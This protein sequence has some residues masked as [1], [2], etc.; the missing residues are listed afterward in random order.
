[1]DDRVFDQD[2]EYVDE[3]PLGPPKRREIRIDVDDRLLRG[4]RVSQGLQGE[5]DRGTGLEGL[6]IRLQPLGSRIGE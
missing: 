1:M 3:G 4:D 2:P 5:S 6:R